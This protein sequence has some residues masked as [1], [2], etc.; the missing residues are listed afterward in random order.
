MN[1]LCRLILLLSLVVAVSMPPSDK[2]HRGSGRRE[3]SIS[4][5]IGIT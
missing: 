5:L 3:V 2:P 4:S 1:S